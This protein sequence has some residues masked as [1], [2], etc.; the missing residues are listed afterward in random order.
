M[1]VRS[2]KRDEL[3]LTRGRKVCESNSSGTSTISRLAEEAKLQTPQ[4]SH[5]RIRFSE[6]H[7]KAYA[8]TQITKSACRELWYSQEELRS[9]KADTGRQ[10]RSIIRSADANQQDCME[11]L[12]DA[13]ELLVKAVSVDEI[14]EVL[15]SYSCL[16]IDPTLYG[17][18]KW[19]LR[20]V[21]HDRATRRKQLVQM[22]HICKNDI[23]L[24]QSQ[25]SKILR[26]ESRELSR[27]SRLFAHYVAVVAAC[28][29]E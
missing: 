19:V 7:D 3:I 28:K 22:I 12:Q 25:R 13:Y 20:D 27:P 5:R 4:E 23:S 17:L 10:A 29:E 8:N 15:E 24:S 14:Q 2:I 16:S 1:K 21:A 6:E 9:F 26:K 11:M 18:D